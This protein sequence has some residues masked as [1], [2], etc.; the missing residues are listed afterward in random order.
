MTN[1]DLLDTIANYRPVIYKNLVQCMVIDGLNWAYIQ[2]REAIG[3]RK[4]VK[5]K[6]MTLPVG[7]L[8]G[9]FCGF[10][11]LVACVAIVAWGVLRGSVR[12]D[13]VGW[14]LMGGTYVSSVAGVLIAT[15]SVKRRRLLVG[16]CT[17]VAMLLILVLSNWI[18]FGGDFRGIWTTGA[19]V[20]AG[21]VTVLLVGNVG[22]DLRGKR[23]RKTTFVKLNKSY[24]R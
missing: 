9:S 19:T 13:A 5:G 10:S 17:A 23:G 22:S 20:L 2:S 16:V 8:T 11:I 3:M 14:Y 1:F 21:A 18:F 6:A 4:G 15:K 12:F 24:G 7:V